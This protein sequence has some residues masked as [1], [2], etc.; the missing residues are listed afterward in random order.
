MKKIFLLLLLGLGTLSC[1]DN[2]TEQPFSFITDQNFFRSERDAQTGLNAVYDVLRERSYYGENVIRLLEVNSDYVVPF[3]L[4]SVY[5]IESDANTFSSANNLIRDWWRTIYR[6][7]NRANLVIRRVPPVPG[8]SDAAKTRAV[9]EAKF[10]RALFYFDLVRSFGPVPLLTQPTE[11]LGNL[12]VERQ[13]TAAVYAQI[14]TDL[15]EAVAGLPASYTGADIGRATAGAAKAMLAKVY[16]TNKKWAEAAGLAGEVVKSNT[17]SLFPD[18]RDAFRPETKNGREHLFSVQFSCVDLAFGSAYSSFLAIDF[19]YPIGQTNQGNYFV[20]PAFANT[21]EPG[22]ARKAVSV[23]TQRAGPDGKI[24]QQRF[25]IHTDKFW[26]DRPCGRGEARN[27]WP[28]LR[29]ADVLLLYAEALNE[30]GGPTA[31][32]YGAIN[33]VRTRAKL[34]ALANLNQAQFRDAV[35]LERALELSF[36]G[37]RRWDLLR[38]GKYQ[39]AMQAAGVRTSPQYE[40]FPIPLEERDVNPSLTQNTGF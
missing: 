16:L 18:Y 9:A 26:D 13:P 39:Q 5:S 14:E 28:L 2:L 22:D 29:Y 31:D 34:P 17:Y 23:L 37:H 15:K 11:D 38:T 40:L 24:Y 20:T 1:E 19:T 33:Q 36:E 30:V 7:V 21:F 25:G 4:V 3:A 10:L 27:N 32:A 12:R 6:G 35:A 8:M